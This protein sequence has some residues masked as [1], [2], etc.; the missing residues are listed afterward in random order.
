MQDE[1][2]GRA[3]LVGQPRVPQRCQV[4]HPHR[5]VSQR[6]DHLQSHSCLQLL[7][8]QWDFPLRGMSELSTTRMNNDCHWAE[9]LVVKLEEAEH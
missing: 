1:A 6:R 9:G 5:V 7:C 2:L 8:C 4:P 3:L